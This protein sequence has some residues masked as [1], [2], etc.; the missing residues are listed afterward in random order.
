VSAPADDSL[1][2]NKD[3]FCTFHNDAVIGVLE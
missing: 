1:D 3:L 2:S